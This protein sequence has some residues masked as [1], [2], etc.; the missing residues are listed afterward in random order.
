[1]PKERHQAVYVIGLPHLTLEG[2]RAFFSKAAA[3]FDTDIDNRG[4]ASK[5]MAVVTS[6]F[7][8]SNQT[9]GEWSRFRPAVTIH[10]LN[11]TEHINM[12]RFSG[13]SAILLFGL[14]MASGAAAFGQIYKYY[15]PGP[16]WTVTTIRITSGMDQAYLE[17]LDTSFKKDQ[18]AQVKAGL[19]K[20]YKILKTLDDNSNSW[21]LLI[22]REYGSLADFERNQ[23]KAD[24]LAREVSGDDVKQMKGYEDRAK[25]REVLGTRTA[26]ELK[27][28]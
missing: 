24:A 11:D 2:F 1:M 16:I 26:R 4:L 18:D 14:L 10:P 21:N 9:G 28:K 20:S 22:L 27:L 19:M 12:K 15:T 6:K 25:I 23:E 17:Y 13:K 3:T 5:L 7:P 8:S